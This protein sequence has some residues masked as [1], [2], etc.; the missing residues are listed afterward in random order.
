M[1]TINKSHVPLIESTGD[2]V[3]I[4]EDLELAFKKRAIKSNCLSLEQWQRSRRNS[5]TNTK[6]F[7][8][9]FPSFNRFS[10]ESKN[11]T[12]VCF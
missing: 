11:Q 9:N 2:Y 1:K 6:A 10:K 4:F 3:F 7:T 8:G 5:K 12:T